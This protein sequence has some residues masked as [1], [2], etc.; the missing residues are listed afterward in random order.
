MYGGKSVF[1]FT[2]DAKKT[3][4][5]VRRRDDDEMLGFP[6]VG[7]CDVFGVASKRILTTLW[8]GRMRSTQ[9]E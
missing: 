1:R 8:M 9:V 4:V 5:F 6:K 7:K 3:K 2:L